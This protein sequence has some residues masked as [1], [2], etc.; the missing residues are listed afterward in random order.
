MA[1]IEAL[2]NRSENTRGCAGWRDLYAI[3]DVLGIPASDV[4]GVA[5]FYSQIFRQPVGCHV[6]H[7]ATA[8]YATSP[9]IRVFRPPLRRN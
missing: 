1:S 3:A 2:E 9:A 7:I 5:T 8:W 6:I 4:E